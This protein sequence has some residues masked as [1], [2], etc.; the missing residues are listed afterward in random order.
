MEAGISLG[1]SQCYGFKNPP[2]LGGEYT[3]LNVVAVDLA[4][5]YAFLADL[6]HQTKDLPDG[7]TVKLVIKP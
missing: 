5:N 6:W 1:P 4:E 7:S 3:A 2:L